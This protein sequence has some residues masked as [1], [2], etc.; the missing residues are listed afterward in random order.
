MRKAIFGIAC[1]AIAGTAYA[2]LV[3]LKLAPGEAVE[4]RLTVAPGKFTEL[5]I[6]VKKGRAVGWR[7]QADGPTD[8]NIHYHYFKQVKYPERRKNVREASGRLAV[9]LDQDYCW[10]WANRSTE[11]LALN[12][13]LQEMAR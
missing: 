8:F 5:C 12:V 1:A 3:E 4:K 2:Q 6:P 13:N 9:G 7:F 11:P 10:L